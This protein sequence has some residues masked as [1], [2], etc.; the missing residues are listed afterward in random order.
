MVDGV[1]Q[2][3]EQG[4]DLGV[5][6]KELFQI[7]H[8]QRPHPVDGLSPTLFGEFPARFH[9]PAKGLDGFPDLGDAFAVQG[10]AEQ[11]RH[12]PM[13]AFRLEQVQGVDILPAGQFGAGAIIAFGLVDE[14][15][16]GDL[17]DPFLDPLQLV[18][19]SGQL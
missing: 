9:R 6:Q 10:A 12:R 3:G 17:H 13:I 8:D 7:V 11:G 14:D 18:A 2:P 19:G 15:G 1:L 4:F 5:V 16:V